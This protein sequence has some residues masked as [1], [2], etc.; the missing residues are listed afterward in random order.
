MMMLKTFTATVE[1]KSDQCNANL[2]NESPPKHTPNK[3]LHVFFNKALKHGLEKD[4]LRPGW[5]LSR[6]RSTGGLLRQ[7]GVTAFTKI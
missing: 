2:L 4:V 5:A 6:S 1:E 3:V 7:L